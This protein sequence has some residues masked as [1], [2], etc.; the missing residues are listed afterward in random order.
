ME[1][2]GFQDVLQA[3][4][5]IKAAQLRERPGRQEWERSPDWIKYTS[6]PSSE[7]VAAREQGL[8]ERLAL[9]KRLKDA[10]NEHFKAEVHHVEGRALS[11]ALSQ[12]AQCPSG[13]PLR[14]RCVRPAVPPRVPRAMQDPEQALQSYTQALSVFVWFDRGKDRTSE[15]I[16]WVNSL[17][18][19]A[20]SSERDEVRRPAGSGGRQ[21]RWCPA[22]WQVTMVPH[23]PTPQAN[24]LVTAL[25]NNAA[26]CLIKLQQPAAALYAST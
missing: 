15:D 11:Q 1:G 12:Q 17:L 8:G 14:G 18:A 25:F 23:S 26:S 20:D 13:G 24:G 3:A 16:P 22:R 2:G 5:D 6:W 7:V 21:Q 10:G 4:A 19:E 9:C